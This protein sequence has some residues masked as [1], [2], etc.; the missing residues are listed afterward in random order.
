VYAY[1]LGVLFWLNWLS[2]GT[3]TWIMAQKYWIVS[4]EVKAILDPSNRI[5]DLKGSRE[6]TYN[7]VFW[8]V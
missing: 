1:V 5:N 2:F 8:T 4:M 6:R 3:G 7:C